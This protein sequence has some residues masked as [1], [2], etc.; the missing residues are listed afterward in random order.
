[1]HV[2]HIF[3]MTT[4]SPLHMMRLP[5]EREEFEASPPR[6]SSYAMS[7]DEEFKEYPEE[8]S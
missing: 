3:V 8:V 4:E 6:R 2:F 5:Y 7:L 1:M